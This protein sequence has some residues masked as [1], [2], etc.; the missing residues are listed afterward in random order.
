MNKYDLEIGK[1]LKEL[2]I[3]KGLTQTEVGKI[4]GKSK[5]TIYGYENGKNSLTASTLI[6]LLKLYD[7]DANEFIDELE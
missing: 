3:K 5:E 4:V 1:K 6:Q 7:K 2:R